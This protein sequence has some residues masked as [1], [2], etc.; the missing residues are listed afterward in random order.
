MPHRCDKQDV[1]LIMRPAQD[2]DAARLAELLGDFTVQQFLFLQGGPTTQDEQDF[3]ERL[4]T[5]SEEIVWMVALRREAEGPEEFV[6]LTSLRRQRNN[7]RLTSGINLANRT[8]WGKGI[9][10]A[11]HVLRTWYA[12]C[13]LGA[14]AI[15][16]SYVEVNEASGRALAHAGYAEVGRQPRAHFTAGRWYDIVHM[17]CYNPQTAGVLWPRED[18]PAAVREAMSRT[19]ATLKKATSIIKP[20]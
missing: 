3:L 1:T 2:G 18:I 20:R 5:T 17:A 4:R 16:S 9:A 6:G 19:E 12:F 11:T 10:G 15:D 7:S 13:E 8:L 14:Y